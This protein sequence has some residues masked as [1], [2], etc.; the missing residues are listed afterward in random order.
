VASGVP[1]AVGAARALLLAVLVLAAA[2]SGALPAWTAL[3]LAGVGSLAVA[4]CIFGR[5]RAAGGGRISRLLEV[6]RALGR[7]PGGAV[8]IFGWLAG[9][10]TARVL[11]VAAVS[12]ALGVSAPVSVALVI[13]PALAVTA[14]VSLSPA[15]LGVTSSA[16]ALVLHARGVD[17]TTAVAAGIGV[18]AVETA[19]GLATG[20]ASALVLAFPTPSAR[21][22]T[23]VSVGASA[24]LAAVLVG[25]G[26][27]GFADL[28]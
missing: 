28:A 25:V 19:A 12:A 2:G 26:G 23:L 5:H 22:W 11:A 18:N 15:G 24:C 14:L 10:I 7:S 4:V 9:S 13:V 20:V 17:M 1:A 16:V 27:F 6:F 3:V 8:R 21:R